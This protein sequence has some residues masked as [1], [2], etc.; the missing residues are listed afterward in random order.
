MFDATAMYPEGFH[1]YVHYKKR[2]EFGIVRD[3]L[4]RTDVLSSI[5]YYF[6]DFGIS[7][8]FA[9]PSQPRLVTGSHCQDKEVP[10]LSDSLPYDPFKTDIFILGNVY[11]TC[12]TDVY[13]NLSFLVPLSYEMT[14]WAP[15]TRPSAEESL[16]HFYNLV[17]QQ[18][19]VS[20]RWMLLEPNIK[21][22]E[23]VRRHLRS[24]AREIRRFAKNLCGWPASLVLL[25]SITAATF[26]Y[27]P[28]DIIS[29]V[30]ETFQQRP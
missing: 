7:T 13:S 16:S 23:R 1:P 27:G 20:L 26:V 30:K 25:A 28:R 17:Q 8:H 19:Q 5:R 10:E 15:R 6:T 22:S 9:D 12:L 4:N 3:Y 29:R 14:K 18:S 11:Q 21:R 24:L 2:D